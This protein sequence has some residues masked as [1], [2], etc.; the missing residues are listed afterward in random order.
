MTLDKFFRLVYEHEFKDF[1]VDILF[2]EKK[3]VLTEFIE[4]ISKDILDFWNSLNSNIPN[5]TDYDLGWFDES[6]IRTQ[7]HQ[8]YDDLE[9]PNFLLIPDYFFEMLNDDNIKKQPS[10]DYLILSKSK[11]IKDY[12]LTPVE[13]YL[14][15]LE[16]LLVESYKNKILSEENKQDKNKYT[17]KESDK[18]LIEDHYKNFFKYALEIQQKYLLWLKD[19][20]FFDVNNPLGE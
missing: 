17:L 10:K 4:S 18:A 16:N 12:P 13:T 11:Y 8:L 20:D 3:T 2:S 14:G 6:V 7:I 1:Y 9:T 19:N 5:I 15:Y